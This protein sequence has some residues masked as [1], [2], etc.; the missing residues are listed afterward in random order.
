MRSNSHFGNFT[1]FI[2][3]LF[4]NN[5]VSQKNTY[6]YSKIVDIPDLSFVGTVYSGLD[7]IEQMDFKPLRNKSIAIITNQSAVNRNNKHLL[8]LIKRYPDIKITFLLSMEHGIWST[9]DKRSKMIGRDGLS[10]LH[11]AQIIDLFKTYLHPPSW[12][13]NNIDLILVDY[14]DTG[15]RYTTYTATLSK[16][17]ESAS[18]FDVPILNF[19]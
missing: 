7:I 15:A 6:K 18:D 13:M 8:D 1:F 9:D 2:F 16:I 11:K 3:N 4:G 5:I 14:Q 19:R 10:P 17:F 12:V